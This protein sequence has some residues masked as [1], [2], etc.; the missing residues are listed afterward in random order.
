MS[1]TAGPSTTP[2]C[3]SHPTAHSLASGQE[4]FD[5]YRV[6]VGSPL[7]KL[8][9][10]GITFSLFFHLANGIRHLCWDAGLGF[11]LKA[12]Y[13]SGWTVV[14]VAVA[15]TLISFIAGLAALGDF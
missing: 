5:R 7:G 3:T 6:V 1:S 2:C 15:L 11:E 13:A 8:V 14:V 12:V 4:A 9:L 10:I